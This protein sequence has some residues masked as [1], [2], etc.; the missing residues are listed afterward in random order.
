MGLTVR[1]VRI[2]VE[3]NIQF[4]RFKPIPVTQLAA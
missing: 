1:I 4:Q 2:A 3:P